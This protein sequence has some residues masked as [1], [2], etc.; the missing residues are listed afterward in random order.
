MDRWKERRKHPERQP[1]ASEKVKREKAARAVIGK[2]YEE[3]G[4]MSFH[5]FM[6]LF[7]FIILVLLWLFRD[8]QVIPGWAGWIQG[9]R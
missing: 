3:L 1:S 6:T 8:P 7:L 5:E 2:K 4:P 9:G